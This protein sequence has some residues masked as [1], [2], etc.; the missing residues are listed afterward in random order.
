MT[1]RSED[2][3]REL[4]DWFEVDR[5]VPP[6]GSI[7]NRR[8]FK[9]M[10][11]L[12]IQD[13][14]E[15][16]K[17]TTAN[18]ED[19]FKSAMEDLNLEWPVA[20]DQ[21]QD[22]SNGVEWTNWFINGRTNLTWLAIERWRDSDIADR[23]ALYWEGEDGQKRE[24]THRQLAQEID[25]VT[26]GL[27]SIGIKD[28]DVVGMYLPSIPEIVTALF[29]VARI[30]AVIAPAFSGYGADALAERL[31]LVG[32]KYLITADGFLRRG[33]IVDMKSVADAAV[34]AS[35]VTC[36]IVISRDDITPSR[37]EGDMEW[38]SLFEH[39]VDR[40]Y[41]M[42]AAEKPWLIAF[43]SG[44]TGRPKAAVHTHG[45]LP[46]QGS[47]ERAYCLDLSKDSV[48]YY[49]SDMGWITTPYSIVTS[50]ILG[51]RH[52]LYE[53]AP[54]YPQPDT[55][56]SLVERYGVTTL[57]CGPTL[58]RQIAAEGVE[59]VE[60]YEL[61]TLD[62]IASAGEPMTS[63]AWRWMHK[64][65]GRGRVPI[66]NIT[67]GTEI[68]GALLCGSPIVPMREGQ[69]SGQTPGVTAIVVD[70]NGQ[71]VFN[72]LG[73]IAIPG[74]WPSM[75]R[76]F[77]NDPERWSETFKSKWPGLYLHGDRA[78]EFDDGSWEMP[79]RSDDLLKIGGKRVGPSEFESLAMEISGVNSAVAVGVP[80]EIKG[81][82]VV[83]L[84]T[85]DKNSVIQNDEVE[86]KVQIRIESALGKAFRPSRVVIVDELPLTL[87]SKI[88][89]RVLRSWILDIPPGDVSNLANPGAQSGIVKAMGLK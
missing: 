10:Q 66:I 87:S 31:K 43:T 32:A 15:F 35:E 51:G 70:E 12:G 55:I 9:L 39:G 88:H 26:A 36:T 68:G 41:E 63:A 76:G 60:N 25:Q 23:V 61:K 28:G 81:E 20:W 24:Y 62:L 77:W 8:V 48:L 37:R 2:N 16:L 38:S 34:D 7:E 30:G 50:F 85:I 44:S 64:N 52:L 13:F 83:I 27:R 33:K 1:N 73:D 49:P 19:F 86:N 89:R 14:N 72:T 5:W 40:D 22:S 47:I 74:P 29:A 3:V 11:K 6:P 69:F 45:G 80:D 54:T 84:I 78:I 56:W 4:P 18:P 65:V 42:F 17:F 58:M 59:R 82:T 46:Y 53:G 71:R 75:S 79:G 67:G 57:G 21:F